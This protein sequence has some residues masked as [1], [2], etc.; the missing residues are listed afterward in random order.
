[1]SGRSFGMGGV[2]VGLADSAS[3]SAGNPAASAW[4][5]KTGIYF[6]GAFT[7]SDDP[8]WQGTASFPYVSI[9]MPMPG[10][11]V[12]SGYLAG[13]SQVSSADT[14]YL[15]GFKG[16]YEWRGGLGEAYAGASVRAS[17]WLAFSLGGRCTFGKVVSDAV[18]TRE[19]TGPYVPTDWTYRDD[20]RFLPAWGVMVGAFLNTPRFD[21]GFSVTTDRTGDLELTRD[22]LSASSDS[23]EESYTIPGEVSLGVSFRPVDRVVVAGD[24]FLR[25]RLSLL[26][27]SV[28]N[29]SVISTG[30]EVD[31][32]RGFSARAGLSLGEGLWRDGSLRYTAGGSYS[33][34]DGRARIDLGIGH[35]VWED[36]RTE[37]TLF[38]CLWAAERWLGR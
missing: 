19:L 16:V 14:L 1:M 26:G 7:R 18:L 35:E 27:A 8:A 29:G 37:T 9:L 24:L 28:D 30:A 17:E 38:V 21:L 25:K 31:V 6:G 10:R 22:F 11:V 23:T 33:F 13:R 4:T 15:D 20:A 32:G 36:D 34:G 2:C 12:L 5:G 3:L